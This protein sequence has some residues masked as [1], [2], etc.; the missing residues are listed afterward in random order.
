VSEAVADSTEHDNP[1]EELT[2][3]RPPK[4]LL[5]FPKPSGDSW[6]K[7]EKDTKPKAPRVKDRG[8][9]SASRKKRIEK[10]LGQT[11]IGVA[12][13]VGNFDKYDQKVMLWQAEDFV[14]SMME[15]AEQ[16][17]RILDWLDGATTIGVY[18]KFF[19][20]TSAMAI[21]IG[22]NHGWMPEWIVPHIEGAP[23]LPELDE[24]K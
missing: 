6:K 17:P 7:Q 24:D 8:E 15:M 22:A 20:V 13:L 23:P 5:S 16:H 3:D 4:R 11:Y 2:T 10:S 21:C 1:P 18:G 12:A 9:T 19:G 14:D